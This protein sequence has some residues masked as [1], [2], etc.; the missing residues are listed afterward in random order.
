MAL[1]GKSIP[2][3]PFATNLTDESYNRRI[4][5]LR[6]PEHEFQQQHGEMFTCPTCR[7]QGYAHIDGDTATP[8]CNSCSKTREQ[9]SMPQAS[10]PKANRYVTERGEDATPMTMN[11]Y[12]DKSHGDIIPRGGDLIKEDSLPTGPVVCAEHEE[13]YR[14]GICGRGFRTM[15]GLLTHWSEDA[16]H[17]RLWP[18]GA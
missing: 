12:L 18:P 13:R 14:K 4:Q 11:D 7:K 5:H 10:W 17:P 16:E 3:N 9:L 1:Q 15:D 2:D 6:M 8:D